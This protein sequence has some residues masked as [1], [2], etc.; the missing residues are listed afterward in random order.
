MLSILLLKDNLIISTDQ[1][2]I[3]G[4]DALLYKIV[5]NRILDNKKLPL[6]EIILNQDHTT[7][8]KLT[9]IKYILDN[10]MQD[11]NAQDENGKTALN[12]ITLYKGDHA[13]AQL[14]ITQYKADINKPDRFNISPLH[15]ALANDQ[16]EIAR[17]LLEAGA[18]KNLKN[19]SDEATPI[20]LAR[21][22]KTNALLGIE[23]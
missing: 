3:S 18:D 22:P 9:L 10:H 12:L 14:L 17:L 13:L 4:K 8:E 16:I 21:S 11:I 19:D 15:N 20:D 1:E 7:E 23:E 5:K 6:H 2:A